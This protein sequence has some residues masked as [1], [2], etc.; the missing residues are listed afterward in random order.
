MKFVVIL[1]SDNGT[2]AWYPVLTPREIGHFR[3][4]HGSNGDSVFG[5][6]DEVLKNIKSNLKEG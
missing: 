4:S 6:L 1:Q 3:E 2:T 5:T